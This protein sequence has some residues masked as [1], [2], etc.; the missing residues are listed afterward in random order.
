MNIILDHRARYYHK[1]W[2]S[3]RYIKTWFLQT[4]E[5]K[6][7]WVQ[8]RRAVVYLYKG[9]LIW[10]GWNMPK[11]HATELAHAKMHTSHCHRCRRVASGSVRDSRCRLEFAWIF[12]CSCKLAAILK[13]LHPVIK[14]YVNS[15]GFWH[16][17]TKKAKI[18]MNSLV[19]LV[20]GWLGWLGWLW[21]AGWLHLTGLLAWLMLS[22]HIIKNIW[23]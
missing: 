18:Q 11:W 23:Y 14:Q 9:I 5:I 1:Y 4:L 8:S 13:I 3:D 17:H 7:L 19:F 22:C 16:P 2:Y 20:L 12:L 15:I 6:N 10:S 21:L